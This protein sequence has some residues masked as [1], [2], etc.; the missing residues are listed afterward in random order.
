MGKEIRYDINSL[1]PKVRAGYSGDPLDPVQ[2]HINK[3][4]GSYAAIPPYFIRP[5]KD[6]ITKVE[7]ADGIRQAVQDFRILRSVMPMFLRA[8]GDTEY[9]RLPTEP[10][11]TVSGKNT[12]VRRQVA[13]AGDKG[14]IKE[15]WSQDDYEITIQGVLTSTDGEYPEDDVQKLKRLFDS[16]QSVSVS[17]NMLLAMGIKYLAVES[18]SFPHTKGLENQN[19]EIKAYSDYS[20]ELLITI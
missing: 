19:Y 11:V 18:V 10:L 9:W 16:R 7:D 13:K 5:G 6:T 20:V 17:Q 12:I 15:R 3:A 2:V 8:F 1:L 4:L 14:T